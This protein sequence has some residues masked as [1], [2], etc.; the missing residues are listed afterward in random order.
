MKTAAIILNS[1]YKL[2]KQINAD[3][4]IATDGGFDTYKYPI[5]LLI[6]DMDSIKDEN[7]ATHKIILDKEKDF[8]DGEFALNYLLK[9]NYETIKIYGI[10]GGRL[11]QVYG[12]IELLYLA[13]KKGVNVIG[14]GKDYT[15]YL[16]SNTIEI[17]TKIDKTISIYSL[18]EESVISKIENTKY[19]FFET[20]LAKGSTYGLSNVATSDVVKLTINSGTVIVF[21]KN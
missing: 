17:K 21:V 16:V 12:N 9:E 3:F 5:D 19:Q 6:G 18:S 15:I 10:D 11:D 20:K 13:H 1:P 4:I 7:T 14:Y 2:K 8:S